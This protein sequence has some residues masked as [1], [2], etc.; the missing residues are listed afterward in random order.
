M[1]EG[2]SDQLRDGTA[3]FRLESHRP[4]SL[5]FHDSVE[6]GPGGRICTRTGSVLSGAPLLLGY[7][8]ERAI[9]R[10]K[11]LRPWDEVASA[12][13]STECAARISRSAMWSRIL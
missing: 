5:A 8:G 13:G 3:P 1:N 12:S 6:I 10:L 7:A 11:R 2:V 4:N 9:K